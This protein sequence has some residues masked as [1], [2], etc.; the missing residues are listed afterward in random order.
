MLKELFEILKKQGLSFVVMGISIW[1]FYI[2]QEKLQEKQQQM[3]VEMQQ[4]ND[5]FIE[6]MKDNQV[7]LIRVIEKNTMALETL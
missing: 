6:Y 5:S 4:C 3:Q 1:Y 2:Q 7:M